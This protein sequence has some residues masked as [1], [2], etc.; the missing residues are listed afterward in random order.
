M[1]MKLELV[2]VP[3]SDVDRAKALYTEKL[4]FKL[5]VDRQVSGVGR[6]VQLTPPTTQATSV[7]PTDER[8]SCSQASGATSRWTKHRR[9]G[10]AGCS[11]RTHPRPVSGGP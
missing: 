3:V 11:S 1:D 6:I 7:G 10:A 2:P 4:G 8:C 5:E 9:A